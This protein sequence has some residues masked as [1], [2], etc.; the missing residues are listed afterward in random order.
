MGRLVAADQG[1]ASGVWHAQ[2]RHAFLPRRY[3]ELR[4]LNKE[5]K[6]RHLSRNV[7]NPDII[8]A[9]LKRER[10]LVGLNMAVSRLRFK[11]SP[12][13]LTLMLTRAQQ[14]FAASPY[15]TLQ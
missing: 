1:S 8:S 13:L 6:Y 10:T 7:K 9:V 15:E 3:L 14:L 11:T 4:L 5:D 12:D 2:K